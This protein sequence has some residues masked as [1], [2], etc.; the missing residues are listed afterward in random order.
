MTR[1]SP[2]QRERLVQE[3]LE[4]ALMWIQTGTGEGGMEGGLE[5]FAESNEQQRNLALMN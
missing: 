5:L 2:L 3:T 1:G 4:D